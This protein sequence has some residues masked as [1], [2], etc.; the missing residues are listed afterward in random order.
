M[1]IIITKESFYYKKGQVLTCEQRGD[2]LFHNDNYLDKS[3]YLKLNE[4]LSPADAKE[5]TK[6]VTDII[7]QMFWRMYTRSAFLLK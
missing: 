7:E 2:K 4:A 5:V 3:Q 1:E 6:I